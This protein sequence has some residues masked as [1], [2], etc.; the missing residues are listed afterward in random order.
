MKDKF[1]LAVRSICK[2]ENKRKN[3]LV[4]LLVI[5]FI[6]VVCFHGKNTFADTKP[7]KH[8]LI[9]NPFTQDYPGSQ[10]YI[11]GIKST[12]EKNSDFKFSYSYEYADL[13]RHSNDEEYLENLSEYLK[14]KYSNDQP[15][16]IITAITLYS[17]FSKHGDDIFPNVPVIVDW[18]KEEIPTTPLPANYTIICQ[19]PG[20]DENI[21]VILKTKPSTQKI[22]MVVGNSINE[23][24]ISK[25]ILDVESKYSN[26]VEFELLN[27]LS[28][29]DMIKTIKGADDNSVILYFQW[30]SDISG[31][32]FIPVEV[33][34]TICQEA[35][36]PV[37]GAS[38]QYL[39]SGVIGGYVGS[40]ELVGQTAGDI[41]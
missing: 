39:G 16:F 35:K 25:S 12:L 22:Y 6:F 13:G 20:V 30:Y 23:R 7:E 33:V 11:K 21:Q 5:I 8:V 38:A 29:E 37:Y 34:K 41:P 26:Q 18:D 19:L 27:N 3:M 17:F 10:L 1:V 24:N 4:K 14:A 28:Y 32:G 31:K 15:D 2:K 36:V 40:Q 9:V